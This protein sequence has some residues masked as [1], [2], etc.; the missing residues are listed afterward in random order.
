MGTRTLAI[1]IISL[2]LAIM[3]GVTFGL[4]QFGS[5]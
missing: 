1:L 4:I 2:I 3:A 5:A